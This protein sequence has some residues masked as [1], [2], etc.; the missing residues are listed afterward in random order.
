MLQQDE[1]DDFVIATGR[2]YSVRDFINYAAAELDMKIV[3]K[4]EGINEKG[5]NKNNECIIRID[6][7]YFR[8]TE[9]EELLG[10]AS[11]AQELLGWEAKITIQEL[12]KEMI[13]L[14]FELAQ[15]DLLLKDAGFSQ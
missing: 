6:P 2:Q 3:W 13:A 8:P 12:V 9:V 11:K 4:G 1:P 15:K 14:D 5:F 10:D 7:R